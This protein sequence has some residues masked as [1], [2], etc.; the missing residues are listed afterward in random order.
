MNII[1]STE[2]K[3]MFQHVKEADMEMVKSIND[4][5]QM[6]A[7]LNQLLISYSKCNDR[8]QTRFEVLI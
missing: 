3:C 2:E 8:I 4:F 7:S 5:S 6:H 1:V